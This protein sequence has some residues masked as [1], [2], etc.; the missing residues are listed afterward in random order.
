M[1]S[2]QKDC[3]LL[4]A[5]GSVHWEWF[6]GWSQTFDTYFPKY[7]IPDS[8]TTSFFATNVPFNFPT[9]ILW[10]DTYRTIDN[11][12]FVFKPREWRGN[13]YGGSP[14]FAG[15]NYLR[16]KKKNRKRSVQ[17]SILLFLELSC[18]MIICKSIQ[19]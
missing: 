3:E 8:C 5:R 11:N 15:N 14:P 10:G 13:N 1:S 9:D 17:F 19:V 12:V 6:Y 4:V 18:D 2:T 7:N 16:Y